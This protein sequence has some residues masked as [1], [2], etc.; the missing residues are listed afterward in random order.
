M[1]INAFMDYL[2]LDFSDRIIINT[3]DKRREVRGDSAVKMFN[4]LIW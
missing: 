1:I 4:S 3:T 2:T